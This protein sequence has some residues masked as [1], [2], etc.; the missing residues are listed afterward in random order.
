MKKEPTFT[1]TYMCPKCGLSDIMHFEIKRGEYR[2]PS[3]N[4][5]LDELFD[6]D[7]KKKIDMEFKRLER[8]DLIKRAKE[9]NYDSGLDDQGLE[10]IRSLI[11]FL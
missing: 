6:L 11:S 1:G 5:S 8:N 2:C 10:I 9:I 3:C 7:E 4:S